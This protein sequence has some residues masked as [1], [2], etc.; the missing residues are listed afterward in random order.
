MMVLAARKTNARLTSKKPLAVSGDLP[1]DFQSHMCEVWDVPIV[2]T[3]I[4]Q[5]TFR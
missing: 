2:N 1:S 4:K 5:K 3:L